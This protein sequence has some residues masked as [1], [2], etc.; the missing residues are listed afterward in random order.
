MANDLAWLRAEVGTGLQK[1]VLLR[2]PGAPSAELLAATA[3]VWLEALESMPVAWDEA[4]DALRVR[5]GFTRLLRTIDRWPAPIHLIA[6]LGN[7]DPPKRLPAPSMTAEE[8]ARNSERMAQVKAVIGKK[9]IGNRSKEDSY[10]RDS[11]RV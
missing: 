7:R 11:R 1:L 10:E 5:G 9:V 3:A 8:K 4:A 6:Q 2:L